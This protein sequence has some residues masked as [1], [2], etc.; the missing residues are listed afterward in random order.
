ML[1]ETALERTARDPFRIPDRPFGVK[2][3]SPMPMPMPAA[4]LEPGPVPGKPL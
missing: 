3:N 2:I 1:V 4:S